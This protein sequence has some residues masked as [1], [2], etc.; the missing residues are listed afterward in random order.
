MRIRSLSNMTT[1][2]V[3][4][5]AILRLGSRQELSLKMT[6]GIGELFDSNN[7]NKIQYSLTI[8]RAYITFNFYAF[9]LVLTVFICTSS[10]LLCEVRH[11][12]SGSA[13]KRG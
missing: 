11:M 1:A 3:K 5:D 7:F 2:L 9:E 8:H 10:F 13:C 6:A 4:K 12:Q